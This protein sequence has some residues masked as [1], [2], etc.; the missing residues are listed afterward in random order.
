MQGQKVERA[1]EREQGDQL[2]G[3]G[4]QSLGRARDLGCG[5]VPEGFYR[6]TLAETPN[7]EG[8]GS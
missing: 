3:E 7:S 5:E 8:Y 1:G 4:W 6:E 2:A